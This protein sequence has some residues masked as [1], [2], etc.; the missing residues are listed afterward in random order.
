MLMGLQIKQCVK[1]KIPF[2]V[3]KMLDKINELDFLEDITEDT[4]SSTVFKLF[5]QSYKIFRVKD[6]HNI[7]FKISSDWEG[8][9]LA[10]AWYIDGE[11]II[12]PDKLFEHL[13]KSDIV[14]LAYNLDTFE[15]ISSWSKDKFIKD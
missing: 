11:K 2:K 9:W 14:R 7:L 10:G 8:N 15:Q 6:C 12:S 5:K 3:N 4:P 1:H 13:S